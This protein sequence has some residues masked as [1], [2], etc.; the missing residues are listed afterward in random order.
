MNR[1]LLIRRGGLGDTLLTAP[2]LRALRRQHP[3]ASLHL[4]EP[5]GFSLED[6]LLRRAG[7]DY[8]DLAD[9]HHDL[10]VELNA[11]DP[12]TLVSGALGAALRDDTADA[13]RL[14]DHAALV[15]MSASGIQ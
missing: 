15:S 9:V 13:R 2:L 4:V 8:H 12:W 11:S 6:R 5:L 7:L 1:I 3:G 10:A 14:A